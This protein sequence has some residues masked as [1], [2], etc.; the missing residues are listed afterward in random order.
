MTLKAKYY[1]FLD[2]SFNKAWINKEGLA[3]REDGPAVGYTD[4]IRYWYKNGKRHREDGP[5]IIREDGRYEYYLNG[6]E[7]TKEEYL[8]ENKKIKE[9]RERKK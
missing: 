4:G 6:K 7:Y 3:Y 8:K 2:G 1:Y 9:E 5:A